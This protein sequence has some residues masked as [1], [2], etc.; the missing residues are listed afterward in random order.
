VSKPVQQFQRKHPDDYRKFTYLNPISLDTYYAVSGLQAGS[1]N[2]ILG[3]MEQR[4][5]ATNGVREFVST[6][7]RREAEDRQR[8]IDSFRNL[9]SLSADGGAICQ[10]KRDDGK[11]REI[12]FL[13]LKNGEIVAREPWITDYL[14]EKDSSEK[15]TK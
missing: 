15:Q 11:T 5:S 10:Y 4:F 12:G 1:T 13:V 9:E 6:M 8:L 7:S 3:E 2:H 14:P